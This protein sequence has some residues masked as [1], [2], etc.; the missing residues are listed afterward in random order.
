MD[1]N[2]GHARAV[3]RAMTYPADRRAA[4]AVGCARLPE[5][6]REPTGLPER[7]L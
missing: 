2:P 6:G 7:L 4:V 3:P 5:A 1:T